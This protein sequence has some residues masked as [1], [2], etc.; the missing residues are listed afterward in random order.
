MNKEIIKV[1]TK[2]RG[3]KR[4]VRTS[5]KVLFF[6][7]SLGIAGIF[8]GVILAGLSFLQGKPQLMIMGLIYIAVFVAVLFLRSAIIQ[9]DS[10]RKRRYANGR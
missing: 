6:L 2:K 8:I 10:V 1:K 3:R 5:K 4:R 9:Y 7:F